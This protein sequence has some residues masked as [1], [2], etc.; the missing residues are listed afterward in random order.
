M[1]DAWCASPIVVETRTRAHRLRAAGFPA[2]IAEAFDPRLF[3]STRTS[4]VYV[5]RVEG[6]KVRP[7]VRQISIKRA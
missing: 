6:A 5:K 2:V 4:F 3:Y 1:G 7:V